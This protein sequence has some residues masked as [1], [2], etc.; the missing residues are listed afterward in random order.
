M[1]GRLTSLI[2]YPIKRIISYQLSRA[3]QCMQSVIIE[4]AKGSISTGH[5]GPILPA[6]IAEAGAMPGAFQTLQW[7]S[8]LGTGLGSASAYDALIALAPIR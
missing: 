1:N 3:V 6:I 2:W 4:A 7:A 8:G 5:G